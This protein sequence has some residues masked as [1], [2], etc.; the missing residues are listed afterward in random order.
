LGDR[1]FDAVVVVVGEPTPNSGALA[2]GQVAYGYL[3]KK[4]KRVPETRA[5]EIHPELF[6]YLEKSP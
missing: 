2:V 6:K 4:C 5:R 1:M 3:R